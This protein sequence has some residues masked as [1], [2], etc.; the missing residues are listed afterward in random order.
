MIFKIDGSLTNNA[1]L[2]F[3]EWLGEV[4]EAAQSG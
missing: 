3:Q 1:N 2:L 4:A